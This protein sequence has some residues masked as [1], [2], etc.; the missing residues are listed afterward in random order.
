MSH[1]ASGFLR[2]LNGRQLGAPVTLKMVS[3]G[4]PLSLRQVGPLSGDDTVRP[5]EPGKGQQHSRYADAFPVHGF[6]RGTEY[7]PWD[8]KAF[9]TEI[10]E[11][12]MLMLLDGSGINSQ[13]RGRALRFVIG[14]LRSRIIRRFLLGGTMLAPFIG[15]VFAGK[16]SF[17]EAKRAALEFK[18]LQHGDVSGDANGNRR[19]PM[20]FAAAS[21]MDGANCVFSILASIH[22][23]DSFLMHKF[24]GEYSVA[25]HSASGVAHSMVSLLPSNTSMVFALTAT[26]C[27]VSAEVLEQQHLVTR[28]YA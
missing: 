11:K 5:A 27:A 3:V 28:K 6:F 25:V 2:R 7:R 14:R 1:I 13:A 12:D 17:G 23:F 16:A 4:N 10:E 15:A 20:L 26:V 24:P 19:V 8:S 22:L 9:G 21:L 18:R